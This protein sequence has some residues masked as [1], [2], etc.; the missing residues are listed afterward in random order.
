MIVIFFRASFPAW[1]NNVPIL[2]EGSICVKNS[3]DYTSLGKRFSAGHA[4]TL[5]CD[6]RRVL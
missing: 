4:Y 6:V 5:A 1:W 3:M 2:G